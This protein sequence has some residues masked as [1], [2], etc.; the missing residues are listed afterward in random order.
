MILVI[1]RKKSGVTTECK[2]DMEVGT[3][4]L[5]NDKDNVITK[6]V[7]SYFQGSGSKFE[8]YVTCFATK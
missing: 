6:K 5:G 4:L 7:V 1:D 8:V 3:P 2:R